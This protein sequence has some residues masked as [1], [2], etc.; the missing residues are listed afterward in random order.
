VKETVRV[1]IIASS[2]INFEIKATIKLSSTQYPT[3]FALDRGVADRETE[4]SLLS[5]NFV[6]C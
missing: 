2:V 4:S 6:N 5:A 1:Q 3:V